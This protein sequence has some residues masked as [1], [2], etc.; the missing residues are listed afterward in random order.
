M[1]H[2]PFV[3]WMLFYPLT[4]SIETYLSSL[5]R[6]SYDMGKPKETDMFTKF[7]IVGTYIFV[8]MAVY[9]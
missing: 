2:L 5:I 8:A 3:L 9:K 1:E 4:I 7:V 6:K